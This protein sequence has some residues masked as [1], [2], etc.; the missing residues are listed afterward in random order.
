[1]FRRSYP[2]IA[3]S[4]SEH[5]KLRPRAGVARASSIYVYGS[6]PVFLLWNSSY[7]LGGGTARGR[8]LGCCVGEAAGI[9]VRVMAGVG[10]TPC[11]G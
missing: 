2:A 5:A 3:R 9:G 10:V 11:D 6:F 1:M 8:G 7:D 4:C